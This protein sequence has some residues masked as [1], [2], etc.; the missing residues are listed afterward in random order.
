MNSFLSHGIEI[1]NFLPDNIKN[2]K[3][4]TTFKRNAKNYILRKCKL[5]QQK[6]IGDEF[7]YLFKCTFFNIYRKKYIAKHYYTYPNK[8][9]MAQLL[10]SQTYTEMLY[11]VKFK[12]IIQ[13]YV[14]NM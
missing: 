1:W 14:T 5:C 10:N 11:L 3:L 4:L 9:K 12:E 13:R 8:E 6:E 2:V 7:H